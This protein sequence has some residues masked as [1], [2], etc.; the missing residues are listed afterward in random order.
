VIGVEA[1]AEPF[2]LLTIDGAA[3]K[4][5]P[6]NPN[7]SVV[8]KYA[9][10]QADMT[11]R[12]AVNCGEMRPPTEL[13]QVS[14][15]APGDFRQAAL[16]AFDRWQQLIDIAFVEVSDQSQADIVIGAQAEPQGFAFTNVVLAPERSGQMHAFKSAQI[17]LNPKKRWK[18]GFDGDLATYDLVHSISHEIGH[19]L[20]LDHPS[21]RGQ[22]MSFRY[23]ETHDGLTKGD[24]EGA[25]RLYGRRAIVPLVPSTSAAVG[26]ARQV[27]VE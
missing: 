23:D 21:A 7:G 15:I 3:V 22:V 11:T 27:K 26:H 16:A 4:W 14:G 17:C 25:A 8:I 5:Q 1:R 24:V 10:A 18:I 20:G 6:T 19:A 2:R 13:L 12:G 9:I